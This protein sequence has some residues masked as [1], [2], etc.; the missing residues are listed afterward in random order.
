MYVFKKQFVCTC[1]CILLLAAAWLSSCCTSY[2][3]YCIITNPSTHKDNLISQKT[4]ICVRLF[5]FV[6]HT[7][8]V[9]PLKCN[10][11]L[12]R[13]E[14]LRGHKELIKTGTYLFNLLCFNLEMKHFYQITA[15]PSAP[16][17][18]HLYLFSGN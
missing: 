8:I 6:A 18:L 17:W 7:Y 2:I 4:L 12:N 3:R 15:V 5:N 10:R 9:Y 14:M 13:A 1:T 16:P 11:G